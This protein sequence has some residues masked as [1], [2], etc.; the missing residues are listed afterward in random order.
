MKII[1]PDE[2]KD[3][4]FSAIND[5]WMLVSAVNSKG[6]VNTMTASWGGFG[7]MWNKPVCVCVIRPQ[8]YTSE[9]VKDSDRIT[10]SFLEEGNREALKICGT[11]SGRDCDKIKEA[12][13][14]TVVEDNC[15]F[16]AQSRL[17]VVGKKIYVSSFKEENFL[18]KS[19][20]DSK[21]PTRDFHDVY[22]CEIERVVVKD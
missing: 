3:N 7:I 12:G 21:Y 20:I 8:R 11:K 15:V 4:I 6:K 9:F 18:D 14:E 22:V 19:I 10:L 16:F 5:E 2:I 13:L 1:R 17:T